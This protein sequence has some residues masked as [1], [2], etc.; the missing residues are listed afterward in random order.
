MTL[1]V[2]FGWAVQVLEKRPV[3]LQCSVYWK[4]SL[5]AWTHRNFWSS[6]HVRD[7]G[8]GNDGAMTELK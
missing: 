6:F 4:E 5:V 8:H 1:K 7:G 3:S 2:T